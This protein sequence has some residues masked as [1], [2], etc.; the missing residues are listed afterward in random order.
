MKRLLLVVFCATLSLAGVAQNTR[1]VKGMVFDQNDVPL[2]GAVV[3]STTTD[4]SVQ[5]GASG[6]FELQVATHVKQ[7]SASLEGYFTTQLE[8]DGSYLI[9]KLKIDKKYAENKAKAEA[10]ARL[11]AQQEAE[12]KAKAEAEAAARLAAQQQAEA[13]AKAKAEEEARIAAEKEAAAKAKAEEAARIAAEKEA[14]AKAKAEEAARKAAEKEAAKAKAAEKTTTMTA[15]AASVNSPVI[16]EKVKVKKEKPEELQ[17]PSGY[18]STVDISFMYDLYDD[19]R[20]NYASV[21]YIGGYQISGRHYIGL[22]TGISINPS[23][24]TWKYLRL[25]DDYWGPVQLE[26]NKWLI[27][28]SLYYRYNFQSRRVSPFVA[29]EVGG[30]FSTPVRANVKGRQ[31]YF[32]YPSINAFVEPQ[33]GINFALKDKSS[34]YFGVGLNAYTHHTYE[35]VRTYNGGDTGLIYEAR[36]GNS[37]GYGLEIHLG[38]TF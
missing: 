22:G 13:A 32:E 31:Y 36:L 8:V 23:K 34:I 19:A 29:C 26:R 16:S 10:A 30:T 3:K 4:Q 28:I 38:F 24:S 21:S 1:T 17:I 33:V 2:S 6:A 35:Y 15:S 7:L 14:A 27:P 5:T 12:A 9:F 11:A 25:C 20:K 37:I 18:F